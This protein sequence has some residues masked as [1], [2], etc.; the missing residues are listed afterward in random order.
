VVFN[1][2]QIEAIKAAALPLDYGSVTISFGATQQYID[3]D[4][5]KK[6]RV[7]NQ[8][9]TKREKKIPVQIKA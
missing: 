6:I 3:I 2:E 4:V 7:G 5:H 1:E 9:S 8:P